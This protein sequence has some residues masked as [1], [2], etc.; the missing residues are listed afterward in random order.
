[1]E[2]ISFLFGVILAEKV[3]S[4]TDTLSRAL[5]GKH[6]FAIEAKKYIS[7]TVG[8]LKNLRCESKFVEFWSETKAKAEEL[9]VDKPVLPR[10]RKAPI[11]FDPAF[12]T[13]HVNDNPENLYRRFYLK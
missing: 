11:R 6:M 5:Q 1:M 4:L 10:K 2:K 8:S 3:F 13:T 9:G 7:I 12:S